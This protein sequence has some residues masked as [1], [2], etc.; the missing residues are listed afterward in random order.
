MPEKYIAMVLTICS[1]SAIWRGAAFSP[2][3]DNKNALQ[4]EAISA[5]FPKRLFNPLQNHLMQYPQIPLHPTLRLYKIRTQIKK[6]S[7]M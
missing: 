7:Y 2:Q 4:K 1:R 3:K 5:S 6:H